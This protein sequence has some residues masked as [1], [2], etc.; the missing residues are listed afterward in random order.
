MHKL[1]KKLGI[2]ETFASVLMI[3]FGV[4]ILWNRDLLAVLVALYLI[5]VGIIK[6]IPEK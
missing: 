3:V 6:L 5:L 1:L 2:S 4:L